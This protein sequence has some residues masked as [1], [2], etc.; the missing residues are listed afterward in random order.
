MLRPERL[1]LG[2]AAAAMA[3]RFEGT[4]EFVSY[5]GGL[6]DVHVRLSPEDRVVV[7]LPNR[8]DGAIPAIGDRIGVGWP[9]E[10]ALV[11]PQPGK[12]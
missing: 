6:I 4:V 8:A 2:G 11:F 7:Q 5:L 10:A 1:A 12:A 3:N 9:T